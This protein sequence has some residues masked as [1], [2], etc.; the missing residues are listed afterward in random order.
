MMWRWLSVLSLCIALSAEAG[1]PPLVNSVA[2]EQGVPPS[3]LWAVVNAESRSLTQ[4]GARPWPWVLNVEGRGVFLPTRAEAV[5]YAN[6]LL[7]RGQ[8]RW[9]VGLGQINWRWHARRFNHDPWLAFDPRINLTVAAQILREQ[10]RRQACEGWVGAIGCYHRPARR[11]NDI[12]IANRYVE[13]VL[14]YLPDT[15]RGAAPN[16]MVDLTPHSSRNF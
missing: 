15:V 4:T 12:V 13:R 14:S 3:V 11:P 7:A 10:Y 9:D 1:V 5:Q 6:D 16:R 2:R 8:T